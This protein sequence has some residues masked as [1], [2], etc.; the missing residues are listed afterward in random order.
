MDKIKIADRVWLWGHPKNSCK[1]YAGA[2]TDTFVTPAECARDFG[3]TNVYYVPFSH[4][5]DIVSLSKD[6][7]GIKKTG[8]SVET[9]GNA[10]ADKMDETFKL[11]PLFSN[12]NRLVFDDFVSEKAHPHIITSGSV[13]IP[14]L[15]EYR[16]RIHAA[17]LEMWV[18]YYQAQLDM[19]VEEYLQV[20]D[21]VSFWFWH[22]PSAE[23]FDK[24]SKAFIDK[25]PGKRRLIGC[26]LWDFGRRKQATAE[27][28]RYQLDENKKL[29]EKGLIEGVVLHNNDFG[30]LGYAAYEEARSWMHEHK[31]ELV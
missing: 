2:A 24:Y 13:T 25:T 6:Q 20:F 29:M 15:K 23:E 11:I 19:P 21:G 10:G 18:V 12:L 17:G 3:F 16:D 27:L 30:G 5:M 8:L 4:P 1:A 14:Q 9:W 28:V 22:E 31:D 7:E 26:Y